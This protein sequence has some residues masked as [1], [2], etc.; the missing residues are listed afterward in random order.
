MTQE[1]IL[2]NLALKNDKPKYVPIFR[3]E[4]VREKR[5]E[6]DTKIISSPADVAEIASDYLETADREHF[7]VLMLNTK[8][9]VIGINTVSIGSLNAS[10]V[11]P[12]ECFKAAIIHNAHSI[13][14]VHN[15]PSGDPTPSREDIDIT[16]RLAEAGKI[17]GIEVLDHVIIGDGSG[18]YASLKEQGAI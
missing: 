18:R 12:R 15:H 1:T 9:R 13:I 8:N 3:V 4:L 10:I 6:V 11:H 2:G 7:I 16:R 17:L 5:L 14:L